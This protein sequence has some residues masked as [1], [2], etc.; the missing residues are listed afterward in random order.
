MNDTDLQT[1]MAFV[2]EAVTEYKDGLK[3][4]AIEIK[5]LNNSVNEIKMALSR[6][7]MVSQQL[8]NIVKELGERVAILEK[9]NNQNQG[10]TRGSQNT[11]KFV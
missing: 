5:T 7:D 10:V 11:L 2:K 9:C 3:E 1:I 4:I 8:Q 6:V